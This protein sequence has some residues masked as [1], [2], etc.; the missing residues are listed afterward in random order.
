[1]IKNED[2][3][4]SETVGRYLCRCGGSDEDIV[5]MMDEVDNQAVK[6]LWNHCNGNIEESRPQT[7]ES[8]LSVLSGNGNS[9]NGW[10]IF[11]SPGTVYFLSPGE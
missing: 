7:N 5:Q 10:M 6:A 1:M 4:I 11:Q 2:L 9:K 8:W 3:L